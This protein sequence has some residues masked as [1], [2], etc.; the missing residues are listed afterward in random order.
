[1]TEEQEVNTEEEVTPQT[2]IS[3]STPD[4][5]VMSPPPSL[6]D[7]FKLFQDLAQRVADTLQ[8]PLQEVTKSHHK[9]LDIL[10]SSSSSRVARPINKALL[11]P[12]KTIWQTPASA[13]PTYKQADKKYYVPV[14]DTEFLFSCLPPNSI[15]EDVVN[16]RGQQHE[17]FTP[18]VGFGNTLTCLGEKLVFPPCFNSTSQITRP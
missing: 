15:I 1:M 4:E 7:D 10:H 6:A 16:S 5:A 9:L 11:D 3:S 12:A 17:K 14:K 2:N 8:L 18:I 13:Q